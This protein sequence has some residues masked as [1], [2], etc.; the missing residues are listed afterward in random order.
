MCEVILAMTQ[1]PDYRLQTKPKR[2][3]YTCIHHQPNLHTHNYC[4]DS[5]HFKC[6]VVACIVG[7][8][9]WFIMC[10]RVPHPALHPTVEIPYSLCLC[11]QLK[12]CTHMRHCSIMLMHGQQQQGCLK[13]QLFPCCTIRMHHIA[14]VIV[15]ILRVCVL[16]MYYCSHI[17]CK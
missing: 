14:V 17:V 1:L 4:V 16:D 3:V 15:P 13:L 12:S 5:K 10:S 7:A 6:A 9:L 2:E 11:C 8:A